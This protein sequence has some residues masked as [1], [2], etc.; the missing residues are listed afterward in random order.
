MRNTKFLFK[1]FEPKSSKFL[2]PNFYS[3]SHCRKGNFRLRVTQFVCIHAIDNSREKLEE[4]ASILGSLVEKI[5]FDK[6]WENVVYYSTKKKTR[7]EAILSDIA[8]IERKVADLAHAN[9][10]SSHLFGV[11]LEVEDA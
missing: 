4:V 2:S 10:F 11:D 7:I 6:I 8:K 3:I 1:I 9:I 5:D